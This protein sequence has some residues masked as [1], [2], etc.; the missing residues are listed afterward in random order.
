VLKLQNRNSCKFPVSREFAWRQVRSALRRQP[1][2]LDVPVL[3][4]WAG[5][6]AAIGAFAIQ[7]LFPDPDLTNPRNL[8]R[9][10]AV[11]EYSRFWET[12]AGDLFRSPLRGAGLLK[13]INGVDGWQRHQLHPGRLCLVNYR[14]LP[15]GN[16]ALKITIGIVHR[17]YPS[18][19]S[20]ARGHGGHG[21]FA[22]RRFGRKGNVRSVAFRGL[23]NAGGM[24]NTAV[25]PS[26]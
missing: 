21:G 16:R 8:P 22:A 7:G 13:I 15:S 18:S 17:S 24:N 19:A 1:G 26:A 12:D 11:S 6:T 20:C 10:S 4:C 9:V 3:P 25:D 5:R 23:R 2:S 14:E